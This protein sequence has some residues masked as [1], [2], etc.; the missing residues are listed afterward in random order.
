MSKSRVEG[1]ILNNKGGATLVFLEESVENETSS[2]KE[3]LH[4]YCNEMGG[5]WIFVEDPLIKNL[6]SQSD[7][8]NWMESLVGIRVGTE[9][10]IWAKPHNHQWWRIY[11]FTEKKNECF[12]EPAT[13]ERVVFLKV[14]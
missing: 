1:A 13:P 2:I 9:M 5:S 14:S 7:E 4:K 6:L 3:S 11:A 10:R 12:K 8:L